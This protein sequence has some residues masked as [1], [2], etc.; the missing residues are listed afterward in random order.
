MGGLT[1]NCIPEDESQT[2]FNTLET[3]AL[4]TEGFTPPTAWH[5]Q[6]L[7]CRIKN[8][9]PCS[10]DSLDK[11]LK[12]SPPYS[13]LAPFLHLASRGPRLVHTSVYISVPTK[14]KVVPAQCQ[15]VKGFLK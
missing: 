2:P 12:G 8:N 13:F 7:F 4:P 3:E 9:P 1:S 15:G 11:I 14:T 6:Q 5:S 10:G